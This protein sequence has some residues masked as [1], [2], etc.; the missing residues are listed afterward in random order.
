MR[1]VLLHG[2]LAVVGLAAAFHVWR[3][4]RSPRSSADDVVIWD[5]EPE[6]FESVAWF[7]ERQRVTLAR[8]GTGEGEG[9]WVTSVREPPEE[10]QT[11]HH[12]PK[13][14]VGAEGGTSRA[15][16][17]GVADA[18]GGTDGG[19][20]R[21]GDGGVLS[22]GHRH[23]ASQQEHKR[24]E[25]TERRFVAGEAAEDYLERLL[26]LRAV[27]SLG[28]VKGD[29]L[30]AI[31]LKEPS[32]RLVLR[33]GGKERSFVL[34]AT[35]YGTGDRYL[36]EA[37]GGPVY[38][39]RS[40]LVTDLRG[41][42]ARLM[43]RR[44][45]RFEDRDVEKLLVRVGQAERT[46]LH[47]HRLDPKRAE[48]VDAAEPDRRNELFGNWLLRVG[49]LRALAYLPAGQEPG[50]SEEPPRRP[51]PLL[52]LRYLGEDGEQKGFLE[53]V[54]LPAAEPGGRATYY[55]RSEASG[56]A[57]VE[58]ARSLAEQILEDA[59]AVAGAESTASS[60]SSSP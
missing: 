43:Q 25:R 3:Q 17:G 30:E 13:D 39:L 49:R 58:V 47:R 51:E 40:A 52:T 33:C 50:A 54:R 34:G 31:G 42:E 48:W 10:K 36:R 27:R 55:A 44:M 35:A 53:L 19:A 20:S 15:G 7:G 26:P 28:E 38:L 18:A 16:D 23:V 41:A 22:H 9:M 12:E 14:S 4:E 2:V 57:W 45:H 60:S 1:S 11:T 32:E 21:A 5:C 24:P 56:G 46:L 29:A 6:R 37:S 59:P 8:Q